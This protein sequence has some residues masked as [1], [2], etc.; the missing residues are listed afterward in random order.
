MKFLLTIL[1][2]LFITNTVIAVDKSQRSNNLNVFSF[3]LKSYKSQKL[4]KKK[5]ALIKLGQ[6]PAIFEDLNYL[7]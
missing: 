6:L 1:G 4:L 5:I 2:L 7:N 3:P